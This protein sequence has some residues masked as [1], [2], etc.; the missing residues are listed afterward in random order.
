MERVD[1]KPMLLMRLKRLKP[2]G[3]ISADLHSTYVSLIVFGLRTFRFSS[4]LP[5]GNN[6][7]RADPWS[8]KRPRQQHPPIY[9]RVEF[10]VF[11]PG[12][13]PGS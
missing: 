13:P 9:F 4:A 2:R 1:E 8:A 12:A 11:G 7:S 6:E 3:G 10:A 5:I